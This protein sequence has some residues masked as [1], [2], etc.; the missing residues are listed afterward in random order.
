MPS[1][2]KTQVV[3]MPELVAK[4]NN[5]VAK[6]KDSPEKRA[7]LQAG[8]AV[9]RDEMRAEAPEYNGP[10]GY[11]PAGLLKHY[12][13]VAIAK[14]GSAAYIGPAADVDYPLRPQARA[15]RGGTKGGG[16]RLKKIRGA[17]KNV[18]RISV[19]S[20]ARFL[21]YGT[22]GKHHMAAKPFIRPTFQKMKDAAQAAVANALKSF[23]GK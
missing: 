10:E 20:V 1:V 12:I 9:F 14:D 3:G 18:G 17:L 5:I 8:G 21:E 7:A 16:Y 13:G 15:L 4:F 11:I 23:V 2:I 6:L 22:Q 19:L